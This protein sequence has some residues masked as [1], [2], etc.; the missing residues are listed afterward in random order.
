MWLTRTELLRTDIPNL[1]IIW[2][3][4]YAQDNTGI[5]DENMFSHLNIKT[6]AL[7]CQLLKYK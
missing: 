5:R 3:F 4:D 1:L 6:I 2:L 7:S